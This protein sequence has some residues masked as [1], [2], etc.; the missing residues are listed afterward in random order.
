VPR[1]FIDETR[2]A[3]DLIVL[4]DEDHRYLTRVLRLG[5]DDK[6]ILFDGKGGEA[7]ARIVRV[8]PRAL[9]AKIEERRHGDKAR[10]PDITLIQALPKAEKFDWVVQK[11]TEL[12]V[13][14]IIPVST[15]RAVVRLT[16]LRASGR[17]TRW[18]KI[19]REAARQCGR[20]HVPDV[21]AVTP[22]DVALRSTNKDAFRVLFW[23]GARQHP[24]RSLLP[25]KESSPERVVLAIGPEGGFDQA[26]ADL[27][28]EI[29]FL[30][31]GL[32]PHVL[33]S[34]T[35]ALAA[36]AIVGFAFGD[37]G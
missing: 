15:D 20:N 5:L 21:E 10:G 33:R 35:A 14:R 12:G 7:E 31:A 1:L 19:A 17:R 9:E 6:V 4:S 30:H 37:L 26:E 18:Q 13:S 27:A 28:R 16:D 11:C 36:L 34:E 24:L 2:L 29:G 32:G 3:E 23:E 25:P 8:G 22:F